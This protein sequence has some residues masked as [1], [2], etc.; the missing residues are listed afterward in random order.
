MS[1]AI[2]V[3]GTLD[4]KGDEVRYLK[5]QIEARGH[6]TVVVDVGV[7]EEPPLQAD[8]TR[9]EVAKAGGLSLPEVLAS[10]DRR[11]AVQTM[12]DGAIKIAKELHQAGK[13]SGVVGVGGGT[14][15]HI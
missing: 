9:Q 2:M 11:I 8:L 12:M 1:K 14:G 4:T 10:D 6:E 3:I 7:L 5:E 15:T 13:L